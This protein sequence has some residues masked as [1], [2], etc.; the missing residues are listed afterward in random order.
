MRGDARP[1]FL[2]PLLNGETLKKATFFISP[3]IS[4]VKQAMHHRYVTFHR[5]IPSR[6][7]QRG[8]GREKVYICK[9][10]FG[11]RGNFCTLA[12]CLSHIYTGGGPSSPPPP[13]PESRYKSPT[14]KRSVT[15]DPFP[16]ITRGGKPKKHL[17]RQVQRVGIR[18]ET[19]PPS[20]PLA[21]I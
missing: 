17:A 18:A 7:Q 11:G 4:H 12:R 5:R 3:P 2:S 9:W 20:P 16:R 19:F 1:I 21:R 6:P 14:E 15:S 8:K 10:L 13:P